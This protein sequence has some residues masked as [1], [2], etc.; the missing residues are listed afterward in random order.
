MRWWLALTRI[1]LAIGIGG[2]AAAK[3]PATDE[4]LASPFL[5][6]A[7]TLYQNL[8]FEKC[9]QRLD[10]APKWKRTCSDTVE[11]GLCAGTC[12]FTRGYRRGA[13]GRRQ[14][15][16]KIAPDPGRPRYASR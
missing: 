8:D 7:K 3:S 1:I 15:G 5:A 2:A 4:R 16:P 13:E 11:I 14:V 9:L 10:P 12:P 6:E